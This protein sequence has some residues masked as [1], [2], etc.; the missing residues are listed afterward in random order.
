MRSWL[1][2]GIVMWCCFMTAVAGDPSLPFAE[3]M[4]MAGSL[5]RGTRTRVVA[6]DWT[7][8]LRRN[9]AT[10]GSS[11][12]EPSRPKGFSSERSGTVLGQITGE[13]TQW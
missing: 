5:P 8:Q 12:L 2:N 1:V 6:V 9:G 3:Q 10:M 13:K 4:K 7:G 11:G